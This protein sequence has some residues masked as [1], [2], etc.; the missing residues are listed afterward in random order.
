MPGAG[1]KVLYIIYLLKTN[2]KR[3]RPFSA[4]KRNS[5]K[6]NHDTIDLESSLIYTQSD[7]KVRLK[8]EQWEQIATAYVHA[9]VGHSVDEL[10]RHDGK[11]VP[12]AGVQ[13]SECSLGNANIDR[14]GDLIS[15]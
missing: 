9:N 10:E 8:L 13:L 2:A 5:D 3:R 7:R 1:V 12:S 4:W 14:I 15:H 11:L 6:F